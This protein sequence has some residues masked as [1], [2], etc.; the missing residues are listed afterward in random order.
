MDRLLPWLPL[1]PVAFIGMVDLC[2]VFAMLAVFRKLDV[3]KGLPGW[4]PNFAITAAVLNVI[5]LAGLGV[6]KFAE[7]LDTTAGA[8]VALIP[9]S[10][11][12]WLTYKVATK[13]VDKK[14]GQNEANPL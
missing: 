11:A 7:L 12:P 3:E 8:I 6:A 4:L 13:Y 9:V 1:L 14:G 10:M 2:F 5:I